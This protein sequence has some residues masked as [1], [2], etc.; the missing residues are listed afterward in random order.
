MGASLSRIFY[1]SNTGTVHGQQA[2]CPSEDR[3]AL[4]SSPKLCHLDNDLHDARMNDG[5]QIF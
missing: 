5:K 2:Q 3:H 4:A 1:V